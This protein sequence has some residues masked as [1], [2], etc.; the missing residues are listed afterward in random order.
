MPAGGWGVET[1]RGIKLSLVLASMAV[2][3]LAVWAGAY[4]E[5]TGSRMAVAADRFLASLSKDQAAKAVISARRA[6]QLALHSPP[7]QGPADQGTEPRAAGAGLRPD[8]SRG[9]RAPGFLK[10]TTIMSLEQILHEL[11]KGER[12]GPRSRAVFPDDLRHADEPGQV[13]LAGRGASPVAQLRARRRQ[14]HRGDARLL[15]LQPGG[16]PPGPAPGSA[17][18]RR[19]RGPGPASAPGARREPEEVG[20]LLR[21]GARRHPRREHPAA[22]DRRGRRRR[23][24]R[25]ERRPAGDA[26][27]PDRVV[28][29]GHAR[30]GRQAWLDEIRRAGFENV[31]FTWAGPADRSQPHA[32]RVQGPTF[33][34]EF[35]N[36]QN[37]ANHI[38]SV[39]RNML[40]DFGIPLASK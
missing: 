30:R 36:T 17:H 26:P 14:D 21:R 11:E 20:H 6:A 29:R 28:R 4:V 27:G 2:V 38:H 19:S 31:R 16:G 9:W 22:A 13:G 37:G 3:G 15:R 5:Q 10:A 24:R 1:M 23:L 7:P 25:A 33:L 32:Y 34:I 12:P 18:P 35:N 39:W 8:R 40:G